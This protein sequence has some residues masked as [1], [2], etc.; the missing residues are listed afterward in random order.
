MNVIGINAFHGDS[1]A[2]LFVDGKLSAA[3]EEERFRRVKHWAGFPSQAIEFCLR[4]ASLT[5]SDIDVIAI[6]SDKNAAK[7]QKFQFLLTGQASWSLIKEKLLIRKK[8]TSIEGHLQREIPR[9]VFNGKIEWVEHHQCHLASAFFASPYEDAV[10]VS[11]D[12]FGDFSSAAWAIGSNQTLTIKDRVYFPHSLGVF[13]SAL[14]QFLGFPHYGDEYKIMGL[15]P[16]GKNNFAD[17][18]DAIV[19]HVKD[20]LFQLNTEYFKHHREPIAYQWDD[21][22]PNV[23]TLFSEKLESLLGPKRAKTDE[24]SQRH[25]DIAHSVQNAYER[26][27]FHLINHAQVQTGASSI[28]VAGGCGMNSVANGKIAT[29]S[30]FQN[31]YIQAAAGDAGGAIGA[32][33]IA[34]QRN[35]LDVRAPMQHAYW[36]PQYSNDEINTTVNKNADRFKH[37]E[38]T[39]MQAENDT[40][41]YQ[42][43]VDCMINGGVIGWFQGAMEWGPRAL[44]NRSIICDPRRDDMKDILNQKIK[45]RESFRPFAP[46]I[47]RDQVSEWFEVDDDVPFMMK[48]FPVK[49]DKRK[50]LPAVTHADG[51]GRLQTVTQESNPRYYGLIHHFFQSTGVPIILNTSFNENEPVVCQPQEAIDCFLRTSMDMLVLGNT[52]ISRSEISDE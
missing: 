34:G 9:Q 32:A 22:L 10:V 39:I 35:G 13:Y 15:A 18:M 38:C 30:D 5:L 41:L 25:M 24:L 52:I 27:F 47:L 7:K 8:R 43:V 37:E 2:C 23:S 29:Q 36:G 4:E 11:V 19:K 49:A 46:S 20:G 6:N 28:A 17:E 21:G 33:M 1:A 31:S 3:A 12:G 16:Y 40:Q 45:R 26:A 14:T 42:T 48:V 51:S 44:G 50:E